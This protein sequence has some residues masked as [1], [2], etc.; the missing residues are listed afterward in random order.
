MTH[1]GANSNRL[2]DITH[3]STYYFRIDSS[4]SLQ[5][6]LSSSGLPMLYQSTI[7]SINLELIF[8]QQIQRADFSGNIIEAVCNSDTDLYKEELNTNGNVTLVQI[9]LQ[10]ANLQQ[11]SFPNKWT[12]AVMWKFTRTGIKSPS[13]LKYYIVSE[14]LNPR[15]INAGGSGLHPTT[16]KG[17]PDLIDGNQDFCLGQRTNCW[18]INNVVFNRKN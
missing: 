16:Q 14:T 18:S 1:F 13:D 9:C 12:N 11:K 2:G 6:L 4:E 10:L 17:F 15:L 7:D 3:N 5:L 8:A